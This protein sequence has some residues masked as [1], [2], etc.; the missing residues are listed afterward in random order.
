MHTTDGKRRK[1]SATDWLLKAHSTEF[2]KLFQLLVFVPG[3]SIKLIKNLRNE[4]KIWGSPLQKPH[5]YAT[6]IQKKL[7]INLEE[8][9]NQLKARKW[10]QYHFAFLH[11]F[12]QPDGYDSL[13]ANVN[14]LVNLQIIEQ[15]IHT[16]RREFLS[17]HESIENFC[18]LN[19]HWNA[20]HRPFISLYFFS[21]LCAEMQSWI[22]NNSMSAHGMNVSQAS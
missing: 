2:H 14:V 16:K 7:H 17:V 18:S 21:P 22:N 8:Q 10:V 12:L 6:K 13:P 9:P 15:F 5:S 1:G 11:P 3:F 20:L 19:E 4:N